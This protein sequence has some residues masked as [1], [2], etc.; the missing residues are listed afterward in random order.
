[1]IVA[2]A[3]NRSAIFDPNFRLQD[4]LIIIIIIIKKLLYLPPLNL[5]YRD[6]SEMCA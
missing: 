5:S 6:G 4:I 3:A 1:M 2:A